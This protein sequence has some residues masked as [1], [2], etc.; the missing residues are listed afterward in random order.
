L[1]QFHD[2]S[3]ADATDG[4]LLRR[5]ASGDEAA[6]AALVRRHAPLVWGVC[7]RLLNNE[8][9]T[10]D[11]FQ[12]AFLVL[13]RKAESL[14]A[15]RSLAAF[16]HGIASRIARKARVT[17][18][19]RR[20]H[21]AR[22]EAPS[23]GDPFAVVE[24]RELRALLDEELLRLPEKYRAPLVLCYLEGLSYTEAARQLGWRDGTVCGRLARARELLRQRLSRRGL[25]LSGA[26]LA[27]ALTESAAAPTTTMAAVTR[28]AALF[29]LGQTAGS[30]A[31]SMSVAT[32]AQDALQAMTV[33]K[34][35]TVGALVAVFCVLAGGGGLAAH[36]FWTAKELPLERTE[37]P[38]A[39]KNAEQP[40]KEPLARTDR[41][42]DPLPKGAV[43]RLGTIR[44]RHDHASLFLEPVFS[45]DGKMLATGFNEIRL[46]DPAT[47]K[48]L[49]EIRD[50]YGSTEP[51][52]T[53]DGRRVIGGRWLGWEASC[54][55]G[56][57]CF[58]IR[59][60][61]A[62]T[63][64]QLHHIPTDGRALACTPDGKQL[65]TEHDGVIS[66]WDIATGKRTT[67]LRGGHKKQVTDLAFTADG[68]GLI[69]FCVDRRVCR[70][71]LGKGRLE[72]SVELMFPRRVHNTCLSP[73]GQSLAVSPQGQGP[74]FLLD[75]TTGKERVRL[76]GA[77]AKG[78]EGL[79]FSPD[80]KML[81]T[82]Q[83]DPS[84]MGDQ[85]EVAFWD[86]GTGKLLRHFS[87]RAWGALH[88]LFAPD[89]RTLVTAGQEPLVRLW[90]VATGKQVHNW[91]THEGF[92]S[93]L[94]FTP[95]GSTLVS[96]GNGHDGS[97]RLWDAKTGGHL[98]ELQGHRW[99]ITGVA[100]TP[101]GKTVVSGGSDGCIRLQSLD[102]KGG[103]RILLGRPPEELDWPGDNAV[104]SFRLSPDGKTA[105]TYD[106]KIKGGIF[107]HV[108]NLSTGKAVVERRD[109]V[110][111]ISS[112]TFSPD[113]RLA[114]QRVTGD[115]DGP[116]GT[117]GGGS[118][119]LSAGLT[120]AVVEDVASGKQ[121]AALE[122]PKRAGNILR[123]TADS[124]SLLTSSYQDERREDGWHFDNAL[125][126]WELASRRVRQ[127]IT[128]SGRGRFIEAAL[129]PDGRTVATADDNRTIQL[130]DL[131]TGKELLRRDGFSSQVGCLAFSPDGRS[132]ASGHGDGTILVWDVAV[133]GGH[134]ETRPDQRRINEWWSDL[135]GEDA[136]KAYRAVW[137]LAAVPGQTVNWLRDRLQPAREVPAD[138]LRA[139][140]VDLDSNDFSQRQ[141]ASKRLA[142]LADRAVPALRAA[143]KGDLSAEQRRRIEEA[144]ASLAAVPPAKTLRDLRAVEVLER[145]GT[146]EAKALLEKLAQGAPEARLTREAKASL[147]RHS[148]RPPRPSAS[149]TVPR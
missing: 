93:T 12:A 68:K 86:A 55:A 108:W 6:F 129:A 49:R 115:A 134:A 53:P 109:P 66:L 103:R 23:P 131:A 133:V 101:D 63:G 26:A 24:L 137:R 2:R 111:M 96:G 5:Y 121:V 25:T 102:G 107:Y 95:D 87:M 119:A 83:A 125:H 106:H 43:A 91:S 80:G 70:W 40:R 69:T 127:T 77:L 78:G 117:S 20:C 37:T 1:R 48:L 9:D 58:M 144:L 33:A 136:V 138:Q 85:T 11:A 41:Y 116:I 45:P 104:Y 31:V 56:H 81:A 132:L 94:A 75:T 139:V 13:M 59:L 148:L 22:A 90:D 118:V 4:E 79:A 67:Q 105:V 34:V 113:T 21:E 8:Q 98:R 72:K 73:D 65:V 147:Q 16:L 124:R 32:L 17:A 100:V 82:S 42:G 142:S 57:D 62:Q 29:A 140:I 46:W 10:E 114:A 44:F 123:F 7:R 130:W 36:R 74:V 145:I 110:K 60:W 28:M 71:N 39:A 97:I 99:G 15:P 27:V 38:P 18:Q 76:Q 3:T 120:R 88:L 30:G 52:F 128:W 54:Q 47:G 146:Q 112:R 64:R 92:I 126:L 35:K 50:D 14:R 89:G 51:F 122:L 135:A 84:R 61:D 149:G 143:L 19:R 141:A